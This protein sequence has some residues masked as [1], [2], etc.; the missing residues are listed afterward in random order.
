[1]SCKVSKCYER[2]K[3]ESAGDPKECYL[4]DGIENGFDILEGN[5]PVFDA[6]MSNY[7]SAATENRTKV[8]AQIMVELS[9][10]N[11]PPR[12]VSSLGAILKSRGKIRIIHNLSRH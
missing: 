8:E 10:G 1:M 6:C 11:Y 7:K 12:V 3:L 2:W 5:S 4:L 9:Q